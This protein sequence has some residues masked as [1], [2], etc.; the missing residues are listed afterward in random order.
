[1]PDPIPNPSFSGH[2]PRHLTHGRCAGCYCDE[3]VAP[4]LVERR[5][6]P[7]LDVSYTVNRSDDNLFFPCI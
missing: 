3:E 1:M 4:V 6:A 2:L 5:D 7:K